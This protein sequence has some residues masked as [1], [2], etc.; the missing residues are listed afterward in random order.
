MFFLPNFILN[1]NTWNFFKKVLL[2]PNESHFRFHW[3][4]AAQP[5]V[6]QNK[7]SCCVESSKHR[8]VERDVLM[9]LRSTRICF[10]EPPFAARRANE[11]KNCSKMEGRAP[12]W[13]FLGYSWWTWN[14]GHKMSNKLLWGNSS[15]K[16]VLFQTCVLLIINSSVNFMIY[17]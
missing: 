9:T 8:A 12:F 14:L 1:K 17:Y 6:Q 10:A 3:L 4:S 2:P 11:K 5:A 15:V 16:N 7:S 13:K